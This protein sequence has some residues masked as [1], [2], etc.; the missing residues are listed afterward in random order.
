MDKM[1]KL[2]ISLYAITSNMLAL[3]E[4]ECASQEEIEDVFGEL[5]AK[6]NR[7][8]HFRADLKGE[9]AKFKAEE[10]RIAGHRKAME[11]LVDRLEGYI[12]ESMERLDITEIVAG[13]FNIKL[14][15]SP[16]SLII[17][18]VEAVP[19]K[20][21]TIVQSVNIAKDEIKADIKAGA[22]IAGCHVEKKKHIRIR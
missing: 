4:C 21:K 9:I 14:Q 8:A 19:A 22:E 6:D 10:Q 3:L 12:Q 13:T 16:P 17:D 2:P 7:I 1:D 20:Y 18:D 5:Q 15:D 11:N